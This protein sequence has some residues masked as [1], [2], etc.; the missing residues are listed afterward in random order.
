MAVHQSTPNSS[1]IWKPVVGYESSYEVSDLGN[2]RSLDRIITTKSGVNKRRKGQPLKPIVL[3]IGYC[4]VN[5]SGMKYVHRL[6]LEAFVGECPD[7]METCHKNGIRTDN[8]LENLYWGTSSENSHDIVRHGNHWLNNRERCPRGHALSGA[9]LVPSQAKKRPNGNSRECL[10]CS[11]AAS[12]IKNHPE[13]G[14]D[15]QALAD[16]KFAEIEIDEQNGVSS[17]ANKAKTHCKRGH[18]LELPNLME[19]LFREK[20][21]RN[22]K[23]CGNAGS[24]LRDRGIK[25][26]SRLQELADYKYKVIM[27]NF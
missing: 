7:G 1:E 4:A 19:K 3:K 17:R 26:E 23:A 10:S 6:V 8:R 21:Y 11:R 15:L 25:S 12:I 27:A 22:C 9:N 18:L 13:S 20:G 24:A 16:E 14:L 5:I 2:V